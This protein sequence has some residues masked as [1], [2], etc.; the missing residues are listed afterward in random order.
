MRHAVIL[1]GGSGTRLWPFSRA[2]RPKQLIPLVHGRSLLALAIERARAVVP[3]ERVWVC[4]T[5]ALRRPIIETLRFRDDRILGEPERRDTLNAVGL[6]AT[7]LACLDPDATIAILTADHL[8][9]SV[10]R[11]AQCITTGFD[12]VEAQPRTIVTFSIR[13]T[14]PETAYGYIESGEALPGFNGRAFRV[15]RYVE[16]PDAEAARAYLAAG[17]FGWSSGMFAFKAATM[18]DALARFEP[19]S[20]AALMRIAEAW[21]TA[22]REQV[23]RE[24]YALLRRISI[25][26]AVMEPLSRPGATDSGNPR[27]A[28]VPMDLTWL[29]IG[30]WAALATTLAPDAQGNRVAPGTQAVLG[31]SRGLLIVSD[32]PEHVVAAIGCKNLAIVRTADAT[33]ICPLDRS[34]DLKA[35]VAAL[36][37]KYR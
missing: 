10:D 2:D 32:S 30:S 27:L 34:Q 6:A 26:Y 1:A 11:F 19:R 18:L 24:Q 7:V 14:H 23:L 37:P 9:E 5:E 3:E 16:K 4:T 29:D 25:D 35:V 28:T 22:Q 33:L 31:E 21:G 36:D 12:L 17:T 13:P 20:H 8:I 15:A